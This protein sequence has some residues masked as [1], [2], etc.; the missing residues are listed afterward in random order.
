MITGFD[1]LSPALA[2]REAT[3]YTAVRSDGMTLGR[4][5]VDWSELE[6]APGSY[7]TQALAEVLDNAALDG[8]DKF[9]TLSTLDSDGLTIPAHF[10]KP[11]GTLRGGL[12]LAS[13]DITTA[14]TD[15]LTWLAPRLDAANVWGIA[16][17]NEIDVPITDGLVEQSDASAFYIGSLAHWNTIAPDIAVTVTATSSAAAT[18]PT[19]FAALRD[20]SDFVTFNYYCLSDTLQVTSIAQWR[21]DLAQMKNDAGASQIFFQELGCPVGYDAAS[22]KVGTIGGSP[23]IQAQFYDWFGAELIDDP[24][25]RGA[26][27][28]QLFD[29]SPGLAAAFAQPLRAEN[30]PV[31]AGRLEEW[32]A[33]VGLC[34]WSDGQCRAG[35][36]S[37]R[38]QLRRTRDARAA[39]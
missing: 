21:A 13:A 38:E 22:G 1:P 17:G 25:I 31:A 15:F 6:T 14:F 3:L 27:A 18:V 11:D 23:A 9:V 33:T 4:I 20:G 39:S 7:D 34:R 8:L 30:E 36:D 28:F 24:Q 10:L 5:Q 16:L 29:W 35:W 19:L 12:T 32:L 2:Q 37:W 26:T